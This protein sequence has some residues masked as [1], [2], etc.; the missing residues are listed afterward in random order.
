VVDRS[1]RESGFRRL[2]DA[3]LAGWREEYT[4]SEVWEKNVLRGRPAR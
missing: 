1:G 2:N 3:D 4:M